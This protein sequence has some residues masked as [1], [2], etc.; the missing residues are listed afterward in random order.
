[1]KSK[2]LYGLLLKKEYLLFMKNTWFGLRRMALIGTFIC[3][4]QRS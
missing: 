3:H 1:M 4:A 2:Y